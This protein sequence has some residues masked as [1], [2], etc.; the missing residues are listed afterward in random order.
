MAKKL[1]SKLWLLLTNKFSAWNNLTVTCERLTGIISTEL[2]SSIRPLCRPP[3]ECMPCW[4]TLTLLEPSWSSPAVKRRWSRP[5]PLWDWEQAQPTPSQSSWSL[6]FC[7]SY[8]EH[9]LWTILFTLH[10]A[11]RQSLLFLMDQ[12]AV[13][14]EL[15]EPYSIRVSESSIPML[16]VP[17]P[18]PVIEGPIS[19]TFGPWSF[20]F[21]VIPSTLISVPI[22]EPIL[23]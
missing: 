15:A 10:T 3:K 5:I 9:D 6:R 19:I 11:I 17:M 20:T 23:A 16:V 22:H 8:H 2:H 21:V 12:H 4:P 14:P 7:N 1:T 13:V 18:F